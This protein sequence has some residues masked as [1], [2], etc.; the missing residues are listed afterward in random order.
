MQAAYLVIFGSKIAAILFYF[1]KNLL[2]NQHSLIRY[3]VGI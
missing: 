1:K 2:A 3:K